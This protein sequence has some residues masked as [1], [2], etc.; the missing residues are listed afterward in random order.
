MM[1]EP[2]A[3]HR[4]IAENQAI[5]RGWM[6]TAMGLHVNRTAACDNPIKG[7]SRGGRFRQQRRHS[8]A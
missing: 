7:L 5:A 3:R 1:H 6:V 8:T 2:P 4:Y